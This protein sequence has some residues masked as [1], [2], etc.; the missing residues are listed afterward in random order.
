MGR[1][2][3]LRAQPVTVSGNAVLFFSQIMM[4]A[5]TKV[6]TAMRM[7]HV[8][9]PLDTLNAY[10][11][12]GL[13]EMGVSICAG[14]IAFFPIFML[15]LFFVLLCLLLRY[16]LFEEAKETKFHLLF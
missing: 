8:L 10:V 12:Q 9:I 3:C 4:N 14:K 13:L 5:V 2:Q 11:T 7:H 16:V 1:D 15:L 6:I